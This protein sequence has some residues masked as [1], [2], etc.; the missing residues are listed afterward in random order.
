M[1]ASLTRLIALGA[2]LAL[3]AACASEPTTTATPQPAPA[4][5][6]APAEPAPAPAVTAPAAEQGPVRLTVRQAQQRLLDKGYDPGTV[7][8]ISG[9]RTANALRQF[10]RDEGLM[11]TGRLDSETMN[12]LGR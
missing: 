12:A 10:Q 2:P 4:P 9:P 1:T 3:L 7:D 8:G 5:V 6:T 11:A